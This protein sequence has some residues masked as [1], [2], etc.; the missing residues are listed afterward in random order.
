MATKE[1]KKPVQVSPELKRQITR[2]PTV[3]FVGHIDHGKTSLL[4]KIRQS[5]IWRKEAGGITQHIGASQITFLDKDKKEQKITFIDTPGHAAFVKM[6]ARGV[7]VTDL[8]VLVVAADSGVQEQTKESIS[9]I[10]AAGVPFLVAINKIDLPTADVEK[11]KGQLA[12]VGVIPESYG[13]DI[14]VVP[15]S[16]KTGKGI[17]ELLEMIVL[18]AQLLE[19]KADP[20][21]DVQAVVIESTLDKRKGCLATVLV[22]QGT[23]NKNDRLYAEKIEIK[24]KQMINWQ[25]QQVDQA[26]PGDPVEILGFSD[27][28]A[29]GSLV[30]KQPKEPNQNKNK[31]E[32]PKQQTETKLK[33]VVKADVGGS[34]EALL[35]GLPAEVDVIHSSVGEISDNDV[36][37]AQT[38]GAEIIG[39][40]V[41]I[42]SAAQR[43]AEQSGIKVTLAKIIYELFEAVEKKLQASFDPL[44][45]KE[46]IG[47][48]RISAEFKIGGKRIAGGKVFEGELACG[49]KIM[50]MRNQEMVGKTILASLR[51]MKEDI[52]KAEKGTEFGAVF[53]PPVDFHVG[54]VIISYNDGE[55]N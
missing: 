31:K 39:F 43:L 51:H 9:H 4:D 11:V 24:V 21:A 3:A 15:V 27:V 25:G 8:V 54:D 2:P 7:E 5:N 38:A 28:P 33:L 47:K 41:K 26:L 32:T 14:V 52:V 17:D 36:F 22:K 19:L 18:M 37:L 16:A 10:K 49:D 55:S 12:E 1:N 46:I 13:G 6:R 30:S 23:I 20:S 29:V 45:G 42:S 40:N 35:S 50:L 34:L 53:S 48:A 44:E